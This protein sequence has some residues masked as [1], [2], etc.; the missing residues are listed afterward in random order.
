MARITD[1]AQLRRIIG[2]PSAQVPL[3][4]H[5]RLTESARAFIARSPM[6]LL[7]SANANGQPTVSPK[8]DPAGFVQVA[9][10]GALL[11][12]ERK[13]NKLVFSLTN[14]L[15]NPRVA[16]IFLVPG[17]DETLRVEGEAELLDDADLC[18]R[19]ME[20]G[21]PAL[22][23]MRIRV[24][25]CYFHCAKAFLRSAL[26]NPT[27]WPEPIPVS[28]GAEIAANGGLEAGSVA[29]FDAAVHGRYRTDL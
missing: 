23:V 6:F 21:R 4:L 2:E 13:G 25:G 10:D 27:Q 3:K 9:E 15:A 22:L 5:R 16:L 12:P 28:F 11:V 29:A 1:V 26:W 17:T 24:T 8:G 19:F 7:A 18:D 20:R 14:V